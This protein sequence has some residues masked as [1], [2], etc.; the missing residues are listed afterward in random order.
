M[1][2]NNL[3]A[4][5][6]IDGRYAKAS[7]ELREIFSEYA[8]MYFR[9]LVEIKWFLCL[10]KH[11]E[12]VEI[13]QLSLNATQKLTDII[14]NFSITDAQQIKTIEQ[15]IQHDV[16]AVEYF[17]K[18]KLKQHAELS[19]YLEWIHFACTSEDINNVAYSLMLKNFQ[20]KFLLQHTQIQNIL[21]TMAAENQNISML[22]R[23]HG[24]AASPTT[25]GKE[26][27]IFISRL[28]SQFQKISNIQFLAK[29]NGA[30]GNY[31]AHKVAYPNVNWQTLTKNFI[32][33]LGLQYNQYTT[34]IEPHDYISELFYAYCQY[35]TILI[36]LCR[37]FWG[38]ISLGYFKQQVDSNEIGSSTMPHKVNPINFENAE[39]NLGLANALLNHMAQKLPISRWQRDLTDSTTLRNI[40]TALSYGIIAY[41]AIQQGLKK[42]HT[43]E[44][45]ISLDL[46]NQWALLAEPIQTIMRKFGCI[47]AYEQL[48]AITRGQNISQAQLHNFI[49]QLAIP[50]QVKTE[51]KY[52]SPTTYIGDASFLVEQLLKDYRSS[53]KK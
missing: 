26:I 41:K 6:T 31:N 36:D 8:L 43:N 27:A 28:N 49:D 38:Y 4:I 5:G 18:H 35:N 19:P 20:K 34:Q 33:H 39:G 7:E 14:D 51:L 22:S 42:L 12:I 16:K 52:L 47:N 2:L 45:K 23:T 30:V 46:H 53:I 50:K 32:E 40:G 17:L 3:T 21:Y 37:D 29:F 48:K 11:H 9:V 13:P 10:S 44:D 15:D 1:Q 24:Q 25:M